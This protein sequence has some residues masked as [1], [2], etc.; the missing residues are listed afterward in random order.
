[1]MIIAITTVF[2]F[3]ISGLSLNAYRSEPEKSISPGNNSGNISITNSLIPPIKNSP[4]NIVIANTS[5][6]LWPMGVE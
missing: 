4:S 1:M 3:L 6:G 5:V 2:L